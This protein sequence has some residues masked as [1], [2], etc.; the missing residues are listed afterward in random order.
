MAASD[1]PELS[2]FRSDAWFLPDDDLLGFVEVPA[3]GFR[4]G[5]DPEADPLA[6]DNE[7]WPGAETQ[8]T[9][10]VEAFY[11]GRYEVTVAQLRAFVTETGYSEDGR[12]LQG[13][14]D[15]PVVA[16][17]WTDALA[18]S[19]W[20]ETTLRDWP[21]TPRRL[22]ERLH[23]GWRV[24]LPTETQWE[25]AARGTDGRTYPWGNVPSELR[26]ANYGGTGTTPVGSFDC[27]ECPFGLSDMSGNVWELTRSPYQPYVS[28]PADDRGG[29]DANALWV[30]RG[31]SFTDPARNVRTAVRGAVDPGARR[32]FIGFRVVLARF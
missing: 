19:A 14:P 30:M 13:P 32:P 1:L 29:L 21:G 18:Y 17:S 25:K 26:R 24:S 8:R 4:M 9:V 7:S 22:S 12:A 11:I 16:V 31:G 15:H 28:D 2:G 10:E 23:N 27:G 3:G 20:L 5:S 6:F